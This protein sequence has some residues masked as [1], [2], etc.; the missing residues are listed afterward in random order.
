MDSMNELRNRVEVLE[1]HIRTLGDR[2]K[3]VEG[4]VDVEALEGAITDLG[5]QIEDLGHRVGVLGHRVGVLEGV[6]LETPNDGEV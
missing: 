5:H 1:T 4:L 6:T 3:R 2:L